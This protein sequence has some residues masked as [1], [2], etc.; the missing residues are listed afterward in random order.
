MRYSIRKDQ[1]PP[2]LI[3]VPPISP[4]ID[5]GVGDPE[6]KNAPT[7]KILTHTSPSPCT[8]TVSGGAESGEKERQRHIRRFENVCYNLLSG[9]MVS[10][11]W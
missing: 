11:E 8:F 5:R 3:L 7:D 10:T 2:I 6:P 9:G 4:S 1:Q